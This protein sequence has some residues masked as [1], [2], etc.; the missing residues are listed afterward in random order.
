MNIFFDL[1]GPIIDVS[2]KYYRIYCDLLSS[3]KYKLLT[4]SEYWNLKRNR[5]PENEILSKTGAEEIYLWYRDERIRVIEMDDY[6]KFDHLT[7]HAKNILEM[8][9][10]SHALILVTLR[11]YKEQL[12]KELDGFDITKYFKLILNAPAN[13]SPKWKI[14]YDLIIKYHGNPGINSLFIGDTETDIQAGKNLG[15]KTIA[16]LNGIRSE[17]ILRETNPDKIIREIGELNDLKL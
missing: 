5:V 3:G 4:K 11:T 7:S 12:F 6:L 13:S 10:S 16:V 14:K 1:D 9:S 17:E 2:E 15:I 8:L